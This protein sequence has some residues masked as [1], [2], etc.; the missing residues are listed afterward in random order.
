[1]HWKTQRLRCVD[2]KADETAITAWKDLILNYKKELGC[3]VKQPPLSF[4]V[5]YPTNFEKQI[6]SLTLQVLNEKTNAVL[7]LQDSVDPDTFCMLF[8]EDKESFTNANVQRFVYLKPL[9]IMLAENRYLL[10]SK[11]VPAQSQQ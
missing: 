7:N 11:N 4:V 2:V 6:A 5:L 9:A 8:D 10:L 1:M 3:F